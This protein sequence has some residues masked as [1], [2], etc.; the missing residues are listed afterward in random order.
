[1]NVDAIDAALQT[2]NATQCDPPYNWQHV[3]KI[4]ESSTKWEPANEI[5]DINLLSQPFTDSGNA[6]RLIARYGSNLRYRVE[7]KKWLKWD[8]VR[9]KPTDV[10]HVKAL[11]LLCYK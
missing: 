11:V 2:V 7:T 4:A 10:R 8:G 1:M 5:G 6:E 3:R 9:W